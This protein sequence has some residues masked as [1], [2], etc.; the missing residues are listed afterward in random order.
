[1]HYK[2]FTLLLICALALPINGSNP[3]TALSKWGD[4]PVQQPF[5]RP[6]PSFFSSWFNSDRTKIATEQVGT[7]EEPLTLSIY[8]FKGEIPEY[9]SEIRDRKGNV[10]SSMESIPSMSEYSA[11]TDFEYR[12]RGLGTKII[13]H[14]L[15]NILK[16]EGPNILPEEVYIESSEKA[17]SIFKRWGFRD[18]EILNSAGD[19]TMVIDKKGLDRLLMFAKAGTLPP[20]SLPPSEGS[21][22]EE[23]RTSPTPPATS[24][25]QLNTEIAEISFAPQEAVLTPP[26]SVKRQKLGSFFG[27][28]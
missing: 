6:A 25:E 1:M 17:A 16:T 13:F 22:Y 28:A 14:T 19:R 3:N 4:E 24:E 15:K 11:I 9:H 10:A 8:K 7:P 21:Y 26:V 2:S 5:R 18:K 23:T 20:E 12:G 27:S